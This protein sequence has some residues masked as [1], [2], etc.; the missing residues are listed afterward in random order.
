MRRNSSVETKYTCRNGVCRATFNEP[1]N[2]ETGPICPVCKRRVH[3]QET[4]HR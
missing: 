1:E 3:T 4:I 2:G